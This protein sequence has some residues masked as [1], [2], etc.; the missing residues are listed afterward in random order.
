MKKRKAS[1]LTIK[2][3]NLQQPMGSVKTSS[4]KANKEM[5]HQNKDN[6]IGKQ[7]TTNKYQIRLDSCGHNHGTESE[8]KAVK[9]NNDSS[10][11]LKTRTSAFDS[12][13][14]IKKGE[15][16]RSKSDE[17]SPNLLQNNFSVSCR[18]KSGKEN[19]TAT[20]EKER[21]A[22]TTTT[23]KCSLEIP[24]YDGSICRSGEMKRRETQSE[25]RGKGR[26]RCIMLGKEN[27]A[28]LSEVS[29]RGESTE[30]VN[31]T[32]MEV[33]GNDEMCHIGE[34]IDSQFGTRKR[35]N[36]IN[37][38]IF[39]SLSESEETDTQN[40]AD[41]VINER[42][43]LPSVDCKF[44]IE[45]RNER[46][47]QERQ[48]FETERKTASSI[49]G[50]ED[51]FENNL[52]KVRIEAG[53]GLQLTDG[54]LGRN[55]SLSKESTSLTEQ[56]KTICGKRERRASMQRNVLVEG[57]KANE[58]QS[59]SDEC[60]M[61]KEVKD[62]KNERS[63][64]LEK[65]GHKREK[66][67]SEE[68]R[69]GE[70]R[71]DRVRPSSKIKHKQSKSVD[72]GHGKIIENLEAVHYKSTGEGNGNKEKSIKK[73][74]GTGN[75]IEE[76]EIGIRCRTSI[77]ERSITKT[78]RRTSRASQTPI[79]VQT[80][81]LVFDFSRGIRS[82]LNIK[83]SRKLSIMSLPTDQRSMT[84][85]T[86]KLHL[87]NTITFK[88]SERPFGCLACANC[89]YRSQT[90]EEQANHHRNKHLSQLPYFC[91]ACFNSGNKLPFR[92]KEELEKHM[93]SSEHSAID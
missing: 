20:L 40:N 75:R 69:K 26:Q 35:R 51:K 56:K 1:T 66:R 72:K 73:T 65:S 34:G 47:H 83:G 61:K 81:Q 60:E 90:L 19:N 29:E 64:S 12:K 31:G 87:E 88:Y 67:S 62:Q 79:R 93:L 82:R 4:A 43:S 59:L 10:V 28:T 92:T 85:Q 86:R 49:E 7:G 80:S 13:I 30:R 41:H 63:N 8:K 55:T 33:L 68:V 58:E 24:N 54:A 53:D 39:P 84:P 27:L 37:F 18:D 77:A 71:R 42:K 5:T 15:I 74:T 52:D 2:D 45:E 3:D 48:V 9:V 22:T 70:D 46:W 50:K 21:G 11:K 44:A 32:R 23:T 38:R 78:G 36:N 57:K 14:K 91:M 76:D 6:S 17:D 16:W 89:C 25:I